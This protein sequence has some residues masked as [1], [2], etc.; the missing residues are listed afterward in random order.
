MPDMN[1]KDLFFGAAY[2]PEHDPESEWM[3]DAR[4]MRD[5]GFDTIR[6]GEFCWSRMQRADG[7]WTLDWLERLID[8]FAEYGIRTVL[9]TP[10]A[11]PPVW[12]VERFPDLAP[13]LPDG[14]EGR[15][16]GRRHYSVFHE[17]YRA[18]C[19]EMAQAL[20]ERFGRHSGL[21]GWHIDNEVGSY[22]GIDCSP[23][24][25]RAFHGWLEK[26]YGSVDELNRRWGMIFWNQELERF[27]QAPAPLNMMATRNPQMILA[28][29]RFCLEGMASF[30]LAQ[31]RV[32][33][34][35]VAPEQWIVGSCTEAV[36]HSLFD[37][38]RQADEPLLDFVETN[39]YPELLP[40]PCHKAMHLDRIRGIDR[41]RPFVVLEQQVGSGHSTTGGLDPRV[42]RLWA[43]EALARGSRSILWFHWRRFRTGCEWRLTPV[44]ERDR[45]PRATYR[46]IDTLLREIKPFRPLMANAR[47]QAD[48]LILFDPDSMMARDRSSEA[49]FWMEI[50]LPDAWEQRLPLWEKEVLRSVYQ[51]LTRL[52]LTIDFVRLD[53]PWDKDLPLIVPDLDLCDDTI[54]ERLRRFRDEGGTLIVF[55]GSGERNRDGAHGEAPPPG[56]L[57]ELLGVDLEDYYPLP[58]VSGATYDPALGRMTDA[59]IGAPAA[60]T[61]RIRID[62]TEWVVDVRHAEILAPRGAQVIACYA[63]GDPAADGRPAI[64]EQTGGTGR[65]V[66]L[67]A[68]PSD[69]ESACD[70][71]RVLVP[72]WRSLPAIDCRCIR[73]QTDDGP[74]RLWINE[75]PM[76][77]DLPQP[78]QDRI[79]GRRQT[80]IEPFDVLLESLVPHMEI[81]N[82]I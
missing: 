5:L 23:T 62:R 51:P 20:A 35:A 47:V 57:S 81:E 39:N 50:Q 27:D 77:V 63:G 38:Q 67:G 79:G 46:S 34:S 21:R 2:Y 80:R 11:T 74:Q 53:E 26:E 17:G 52:G 41:P 4:L 73:L 70:L 78:V 28:Y 75:S 69:P 6:V 18:L 42:R 1:T 37:I 15:F 3:L 8:G 12:I 13:L 49:V 68:V 54:V 56:M 40:A 66:Y 36:S 10:S 24:A 59:D 64:T 45:R 29:N 30:I 33:R 60:V 43:W 19:E 14:R 65:A 82:A 72:A 58:P 25:L 76:A 7:S 22:S 9:C 31:A 48:A 71:Y 55:P 32:L 16:G 44:V 61:G